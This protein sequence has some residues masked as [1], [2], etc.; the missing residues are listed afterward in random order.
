MGIAARESEGWREVEIV[1]READLY[2]EQCRPCCEEISTRV[3]SEEKRQVLLNE[4]LRGIWPANVEDNTPGIRLRGL[5]TIVAA[6]ADDPEV[7]VVPAAKD[8]RSSNAVLPA[9]V[10]LLDSSSLKFLVPALE[11]S[12]SISGCNQKVWA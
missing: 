6:G 10:S 5:N 7:A 12:T 4:A 8:D 1:Y 11:F 2:N 3:A 9:W